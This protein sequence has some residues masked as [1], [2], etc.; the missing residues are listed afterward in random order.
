MPMSEISPIITQN[1]KYL[2]LGCLRPFLYL[3]RFKSQ[4]LSIPP[5]PL[6]KHDLIP[7]QYHL[8]LS[9]SVL[10]IDIELYRMTIYIVPWVYITVPNSI[11]N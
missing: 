10:L 3:N 5:A 2:S 11:D 8:V 1:T 4:Y 9:S 6:S 7:A